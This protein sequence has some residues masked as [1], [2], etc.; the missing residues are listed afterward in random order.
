MTDRTFANRTAIVGMATSDFR[1]LYREPDPERT[2]VGMA[3]DAVADA[4]ADAGLTR[5]DI[6]GFVYSSAANPPFSYQPAAFRL[7]FNDV[8]YMQMFTDGGRAFPAMLGHAAM[9][10]MHGMARTIVLVH[11]IAFR[12]QG[13]RF[14]VQSRG[15]DLYDAAYGLASPGAHYAMSWSHY[16]ARYGGR[17]EDMAAIPIAFRRHAN[18]NPVAIMRDR[19][20]DLGTYLAAPYLAK[21][22]RL[23]DYCLVNDGAVA[24]VLTSAEHARDLPQPPVLVTSVAQQA[25]LREQYTNEDFCF[26][27]LGR[28]KR[29]LFDDVGLGIGDVDTIQMYDNFPPPV[30]WGLE[31]LGL[32]PRGEGLQWIQDG[33]IEL[34][35][36]MPMNTSGGMLSEA[37][38]QS[39]NQHAE[40][41]RQLRGQAGPRQVP[42]CRHALY[43]GLSTTPGA[44]LFTRG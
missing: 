20:L 44:S 15:G 7:G 36:E 33:R 41:V 24:F 12:T 42:D 17:D 26:E 25:A 2:A 19:P 8:R 28:M 5:A 29:D 35:G 39:F 14:G 6:D 11:S 3:V 23:Y 43:Y 4:I 38:L 31:G 16:R 10:I 34:G 37:Y 13:T 21:P 30:V 32:A 9:A 27:A 22:F 40:I 1:R 18:L